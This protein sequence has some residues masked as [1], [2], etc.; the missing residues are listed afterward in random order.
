MTAR[1]KGRS[2]GKAVTTVPSPVVGAAV[3][4]ST[5]SVGTARPPGFNSWDD[6]QIA[7][8][9]KLAR[10]LD[11]AQKIV[12]ASRRK[13]GGQFGL[14]GLLG[15]AWLIVHGAM[16]EEATWGRFGR[17]SLDDL[18]TAQKAHYA[19]VM[20]DAAE[21]MKA[22]TLVGAAKILSDSVEKMWR[23]A[24]Q[25]IVAEGARRP[26]AP[27]ANRA[28]RPRLLTTAARKGATAA[29]HNN[30]RVASTSA[31]DYNKSMQT[32]TQTATKAGRATTKRR[33]TEEPENPVGEAIKAARLAANLTQAELA[34][35]L[36]STKGN[37]SRLERGGSQAST[38]TLQRIAA[39]TGKRITVRFE[40]S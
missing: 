17:I 1:E 32:A 27:F 10:V 14:L 33:A 23:E 15:K 8:E 37:I 35:R 18:L 38:R 5:R 26:L 7:E 4:R 40:P 9:A 2:A 11:N 24:W 31:A 30:A 29:T 25:G 19:R 20:D 28:L 6:F 16:R 13:I 3:T 36:G 22:G 12:E 21:I 34:A 39:A